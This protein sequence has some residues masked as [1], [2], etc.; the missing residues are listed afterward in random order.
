LSNSILPSPVRT[1]GTPFV[2]KC[3]R[4]SLNALGW[5]T[6][7]TGT[8][9]G[10]IASLFFA[11]YTTGGAD[12]WQNYRI[13]ITFDNAAIPQIGGTPGVSLGTFFMV[14]RG[15]MFRSP[16]V[17][18]HYNTEENA[19]YQFGGQVRY[20]MPFGSAWKVELYAPA[21]TEAVAFLNVRGQTGANSPLAA[22]VYGGNNHRLHL[23]ER[24][25][26]A[27][28]NEAVTL[29]DHVGPC[30]LYGLYQDWVGTTVASYLEG[31]YRTYIGSGLTLAG[32]ESG[33]EDAFDG[34]FYF[35]DA[36]YAEELA[37]CRYRTGVYTTAYRFW[38]FDHAMFDRT[39]L[40]LVWNNSEP[41]AVEEAAWT[42]W[43]TLFYSTTAP[44]WADLHAA[45][46]VNNTLSAVGNI[47]ETVDLA[48]TASREADVKEYEIR[49]DGVLIA[50][51]PYFTLEYSDDVG[52]L[53]SHNYT[54]KVRNFWG[55]VSSLSDAVASTVPVT[56]A[57]N[58]AVDLQSAG[59]PNPVDVWVDATA[60]SNN[61][62]TT[63]LGVGADRVSGDGGLVTSR[64]GAGQE[65]FIQDS[66][67]LALGNNFTIALRLKFNPFFTEANWGS[68]PLTDIGNL[69]QKEPTPG[70]F[71][72]WRVMF[73]NYH[74]V[75][76]GTYTTDVALMVAADNTFGNIETFRTDGGDLT[77][78][79]L[80]A[81]HTLTIVHSAANN[82]VKFYWDQVLVKTVN[83][84]HT[85]QNNT[86]AIKIDLLWA[87]YH[88]I[89]MWSRDLTND[90]ATGD[91]FA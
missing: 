53:V 80:S 67:S 36:P 46:A 71:L 26:T 5:T 65:L 40:K 27:A 4:L 17:G 89:R 18:T 75:G 19:P 30:L 62:A 34:S 90:E 84:S 69:L 21:D 22:R 60:N 14:L 87:S 48:W 88:K 70:G 6:L 3:E 68:G 16:R 78:G 12:I 20:P 85:L 13:R 63:V 83:D 37:G 55:D 77:L 61:A 57:T 56:L 15:P 58:L 33:T 2:T 52:D 23:V 73:N 35:S 74:P 66:A 29:L 45:P 59:M 44:V 11:L 10:W 1:I 64:T 28:F 42:R 49:R 25:K 8:G 79:D 82:T 81:Y 39:R 47:D 51:V 9:Q 31:N 86:A 91:V 76:D 7:A 32:E 38:D 24:T 50:T 54:I 41:G 72:E 43:S